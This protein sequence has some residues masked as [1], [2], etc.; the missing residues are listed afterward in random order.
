MANANFWIKKAAFISSLFDDFL[1]I[2]PKQKYFEGK[3]RYFAKMFH[4][5][6]S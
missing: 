3:K 6:L 5:D 1:L 4:V 2:F